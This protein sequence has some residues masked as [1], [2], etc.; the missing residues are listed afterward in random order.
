MADR[1][2]GGWGGG[3]EG[4]EPQDLSRLIDEM[5]EMCDRLRDEVGERKTAMSFPAISPV[6]SISSFQ[7]HSRTLALS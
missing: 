7:P 5:C 2:R 1:D 3:E 4:W 6:G